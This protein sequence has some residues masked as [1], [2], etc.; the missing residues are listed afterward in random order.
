MPRRRCPVR[1][2]AP[3]PFPLLPIPRRRCRAGHARVG[4]S[5]GVH[6]PT[7]GRLMTMGLPAIM[8]RTR[9]EARPPPGFKRANEHNHR[10]SDVGGTLCACGGRGWGAAVLR[11]TNR[12][13]CVCVRMSS[14]D[15]QWTPVCVSGSGAPGGSRYPGLAGT[16]NPTRARAPVGLLSSFCSAL[17]PRRSS[18]CVVSRSLLCR[19]THNKDN[20]NNNNVP[21]AGGSLRSTLTPPARRRPIP[22]R[23]PRPFRSPPRPPRP[24]R[25][26]PLPLPH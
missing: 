15:L 24:A 14:R 5:P 8:G 10:Q 6:R 17:L 9:G 21:R 16:S 18:T 20:N 13:V 26:P 11:R 25:P 12:A 22:P 19:A 23:I 7:C 4:A 3:R 1:G 2:L